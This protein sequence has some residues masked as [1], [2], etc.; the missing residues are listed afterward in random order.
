SSKGG[1]RLAGNHGCRKIPWGDCSRYANRLANNGWA[2]ARQWGG[3]GVAIGALG[4]FGEPFDESCGVQYFAARLGQRL[5]LF[6]C[7]NESN[8]IGIGDDKREPFA[9]Y[10]SAFLGRFCRPC[11]KR[12]G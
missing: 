11:R 4:F 7:H 2:L 8:V 5:A 9:Q 3:D 6:G 12:S 1:G 10:S